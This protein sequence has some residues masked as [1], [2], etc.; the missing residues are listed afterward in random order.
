MVETGKSQQGTAIVT[1]ASTG[2]G[3]VYAHRLAKR[4]FYLILVARRHCRR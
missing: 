1:G 3:V 4:G 2:I